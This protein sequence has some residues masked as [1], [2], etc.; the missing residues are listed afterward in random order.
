MFSSNIFA[1]INDV[2][3][4]KIPKKFQQTCQKNMMKILEV[5]AA[6]YQVLN[7]NPNIIKITKNHF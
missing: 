2:R 3:L 6:K 1:I 7:F 5:S 4:K